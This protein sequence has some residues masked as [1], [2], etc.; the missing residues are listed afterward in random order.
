MTGAARPNPRNRLRSGSVSWIAEGVKLG[1]VGIYTDATAEI[2]LFGE[3]Q[4]TA[5]STDATLHVGE[6]V[7]DYGVAVT[8]VE[9][10]AEEKPRWI[11]IVAGPAHT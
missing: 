11:R 2:A 6:T 10:Q 1:V 3:S 5:F 4:G 7:T 9:C 8:I